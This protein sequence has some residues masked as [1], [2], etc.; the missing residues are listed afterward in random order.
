MVKMCS[1]G[2]WSDI[3]MFDWILDKTEGQKF[4]IFKWLAKSQVLTIQLSETQIAWYFN[5][6]QVFG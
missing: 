2:K 3:Q 4:L 6:C 1:V 5:G